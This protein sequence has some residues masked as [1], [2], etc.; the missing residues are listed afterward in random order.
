MR[1][2]PGTETGVGGGPL[3]VVAGVADPN[4]KKPPQYSHSVGEGGAAPVETDEKTK[5]PP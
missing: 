5:N 1:Y 4:T 3:D 2:K